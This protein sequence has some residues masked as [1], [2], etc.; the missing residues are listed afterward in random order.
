MSCELF[1][2]EIGTE[3]CLLHDSSAT[4][5][6]FK[7]VGIV[8]TGKQLPISMFEINLAPVPSKELLLLR[9]QNYQKG[10]ALKIES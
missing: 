3:L 1:K 4:K 10:I 2:Q 7:V 6:K 5:K 9:D 8:M